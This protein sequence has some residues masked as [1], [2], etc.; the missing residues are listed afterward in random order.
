MRESESEDPFAARADEYLSAPN[1]PGLAESPRGLQITLIFVILLDKEF[2]ADLSL[3]CFHPECS[4]AK[5]KMK[6][7]FLKAPLSGL[8]KQTFR[9]PFS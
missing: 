3:F 6:E 8:R 4:V 1:L 7:N 5:G 9:G 2:P